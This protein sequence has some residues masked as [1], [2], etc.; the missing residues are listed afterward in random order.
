MNPPAHVEAAAKT[1][2]DWIKGQEAAARVDAAM[3]VVREWLQSNEDRRRRLNEIRIL[4]YE[5]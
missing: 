4:S 5:H 1:V 2:E 3:K